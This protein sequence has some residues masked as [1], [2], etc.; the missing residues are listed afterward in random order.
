VVDP[1][2]SAAPNH[3]DVI[4]PPRITKKISA[5]IDK[6]PVTKPNSNIGAFATV[7][8][9]PEKIASMIPVMTRAIAEVTT[10]GHFP[11]FDNHVGAIKGSRFSMGLVE[12]RRA[13]RNPVKTRPKIKP[14]CHSRPLLWARLAPIPA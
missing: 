4:A 8:G 9:G 2:G 12:Y 7:T 14:V 13:T 11:Y 10:A 1:K 6:M 5:G 3:F